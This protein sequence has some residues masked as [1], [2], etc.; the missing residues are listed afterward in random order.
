MIDSIANLFPDINYMIIASKT[1]KDVTLFD[2]VS[3]NEYL[4]LSGYMAL[5]K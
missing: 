5:N 4:S 3:R 2:S 1:Y